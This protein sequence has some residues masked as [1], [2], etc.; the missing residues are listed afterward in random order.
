VVPADAAWRA[1]VASG[2]G[3]SYT[4]SPAESLPPDAPGADRDRGLTATLTKSVDPTTLEES[5]ELALHRGDTSEGTVTLEPGRD[6]QQ[7]GYLFRYQ[8]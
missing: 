7:S 3:S 1:F 4:F 8:A 5:Y 2:E 6:V